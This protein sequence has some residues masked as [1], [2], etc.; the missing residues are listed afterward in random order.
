MAPSV[1]KSAA[2]AGRMRR[3][4]VQ[5]PVQDRS[6]TSRSA[7]KESFTFPM[8]ADTD[9]YRAGDPTR[10]AIVDLT[11]AARYWR[12]RCGKATSSR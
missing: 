6:A 3:I 10:R 7:G 12:W 1:A 11:A 2:V 9:F 8:L 4:C 5:G